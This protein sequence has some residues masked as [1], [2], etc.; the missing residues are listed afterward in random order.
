MYFKIVELT[1]IKSFKGCTY[2]IFSLSTG[3]VLDVC[4]LSAALDTDF[5]LVCDEDLLFSINLELIVNGVRIKSLNLIVVED[6]PSYLLEVPG[7]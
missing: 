1:N 5:L 7:D 3:S 4:L 6:A 2:L